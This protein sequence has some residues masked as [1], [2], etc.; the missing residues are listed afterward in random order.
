[1]TYTFKLARRLAVSRTLGMLPALL[2]FAACSGG[3]P[4]APDSVG[5]SNPPG[6]S[7]E[8]FQPTVVRGAI[9]SVEPSKP[10][11][12]EGSAINFAVTVLVVVAVPIIALIALWLAR[13]P[14]PVPWQTVQWL[15]ITLGIWIRQGLFNGGVDLT[16]FIVS[17]TVAFAVYPGALRFL[18]KRRPQPGL[19]HVALPF[20]L[21]FFFDLTMSV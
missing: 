7:V 19:E 5:P 14:C 12:V 11:H 10:P 2:L 9:A 17:A 16:S 15:L 3:D 6:S 18:E 21:G 4:A 1:M 8:Q 13:L 20:S